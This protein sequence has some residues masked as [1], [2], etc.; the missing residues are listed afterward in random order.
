M[1][2]EDLL[3]KLEE[4]DIT[5]LDNQQIAS[6]MCEGSVQSACIQND[7]YD[8]PI[9]QSIIQDL[10]QIIEPD[11]TPH[12]LFGGLDVQSPEQQSTTDFDLPLN[13]PG[14]S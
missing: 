4:S 11:A 2:A 10:A 9:D 5:V 1:N 13:T 7:D 3:R 6:A 8:V 14:M 12:V